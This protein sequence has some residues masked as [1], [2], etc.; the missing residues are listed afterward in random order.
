M[1]ETKE[2]GE[3]QI[4]LIDFGIAAKFK[5]ESKS[6]NSKILEALNFKGN[7]LFSSV[8]Q[9]EFRVT[10]RKDDLFSLCYFIFYYLNDKNIP[11]MT[12]E[13]SL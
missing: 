1:I 5:D 13:Q 12:K 9:M 2:N 6:E 3:F 8:D 4:I 7:L 11:G 10:S